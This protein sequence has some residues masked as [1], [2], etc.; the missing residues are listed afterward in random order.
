MSPIE[1]V[2][3]LRQESPEFLGKVPDKRAALIIR[4]ALARLAQEIRTCNEGVVKVQ[5]LGN[6][7][8]RNIEKVQ[9]GQK[10]VLKNVMFNA[11][12]PG[13]KKSA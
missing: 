8:I 2:E 4:A 5:A 1:L 11:A 12:K 3:I 9:D 13:I 10:A 6:F 7:R